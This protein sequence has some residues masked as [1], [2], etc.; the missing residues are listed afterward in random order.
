MDEYYLT[1]VLI[2]IFISKFIFQSLL[3]L[4]LFAHTSSLLKFAIPIRARTGILINQHILAQAKAI[5]FHIKTHVMV[6]LNLHGR[7]EIQSE[8]SFLFSK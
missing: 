2:E 5:D 3:G 6:V 4:H 7:M 1:L 8:C